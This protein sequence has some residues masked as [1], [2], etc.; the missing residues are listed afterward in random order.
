MCWRDDGDAHPVRAVPLHQATA[1]H[2]GIGGAESN[3]AMGLAA[4]GLDSHWVG[5]IGQDG[6]GTRILNELSGHGVGVAGVEVDPVL[7]TGL[8][9][10]VPAQESDPDGGSSSC[11]TG[12]GVRPRPW[13]APRWPIPPLPACSKTR[14]SST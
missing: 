1:L 13:D 11:T 5:R 14:P 10:K 4:M 3:V 9:V 12:K 8:Y 2:C 6:F 7:P